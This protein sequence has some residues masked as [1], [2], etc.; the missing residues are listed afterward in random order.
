MV[1][2]E[3]FGEAGKMEQVGRY[4]HDWANP[5]LT[6]FCPGATGRATGVIFLIRFLDD[7]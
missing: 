4:S 7:S 3:C 2:Q 1:E 5:M 6:A